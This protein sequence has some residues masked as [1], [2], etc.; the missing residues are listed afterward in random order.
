MIRLKDATVLARMSIRF[1]KWN[2]KSFFRFFVNFV[3]LNIVRKCMMMIL[4]MM[5][6]IY[7]DRAF[8]KNLL[9]KQK[10]KKE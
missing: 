4:M 5:L 9:K 2:F 3:F 7:D 10:K 6:I 8:K 1:E